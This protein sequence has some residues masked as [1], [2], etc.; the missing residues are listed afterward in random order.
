MLCKNC[1][2]EIDNDSKFCEFCGNKISNGYREIIEQILTEKPLT[3]LEQLNKKI[4]YRILKVLYLLGI[5]LGITMS[6]GI[7]IADSE[8]IAFFVLTLITFLISE[9]IKR[10]F[11]YIYFGKI[12]PK[13]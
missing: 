4:W 6:L 9:F 3:I 5:I 8:P 10:S 1:Q 11:Y 7:A 13:K 2:K 12:F